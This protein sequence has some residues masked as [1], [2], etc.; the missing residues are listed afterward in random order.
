MALIKALASFVSLIILGKTP[1]HICPFFF[2]ASLIA[3]SKKNGGIHPI[4]VGCTL[5]RLAA[6]YAVFRIKDSL[7][8]SV[9]AFFQ[10]LIGC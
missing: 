6:K 5:R 3:L 10:F 4:A 2:G 1:D 7:I 8:S 9:L